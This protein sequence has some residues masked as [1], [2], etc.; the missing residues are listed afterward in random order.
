MIYSHKYDHKRYLSHTLA[1]LLV[2]KIKESGIEFDEITSIPS[3]KKRNQ[4]RG[5]DHA[6]DIAV[7]V[8]NILNKP[9][10]KRLKRVHHESAQVGLSKLERYENMTYAFDLV[11]NPEV[12]ASILIIDDIYTT[13]ATMIAAARCFKKTNCKLFGATVFYTPIHK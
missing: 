8:G 10:V 4:M 7:E 5:C 6:Y 1:H 2:K 9:V 13:G 11:K 3:G 12:N